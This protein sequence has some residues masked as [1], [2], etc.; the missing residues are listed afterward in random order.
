MSE[1]VER[2][3]SIKIFVAPIYYAVLYFVLLMLTQG[4]IFERTPEKNI[5]TT[6]DYHLL[7]SKPTETKWLLHIIHHCTMFSSK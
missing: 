5:S 3:G 7:H 6:A 2:Q 1:K 4:Q